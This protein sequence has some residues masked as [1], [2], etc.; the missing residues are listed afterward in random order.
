MRRHLIA[1]TPGRHPSLVPW[2]VPH[3]GGHRG[4]GF[5]GNW[6]FSLRGTRWYLLCGLAR[7]SQPLAWFMRLCVNLFSHPRAY[8][9]VNAVA[10]THTHL[11]LVPVPGNSDYHNFLGEFREGFLA[12]DDGRVCRVSFCRD[13][14]G[15]WCAITL[16]EV[17]MFGIR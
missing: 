17:T 12:E 11:F 5:H 1:W 4:T 8:L 10:H 7:G 3:P 2:R 14:L 13:E 15:G 9:R 16:H 6:D